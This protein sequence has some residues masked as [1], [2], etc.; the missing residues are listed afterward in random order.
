MGVM[1]LCGVREGIEGLH[2]GLN[3]DYIVS[4]ESPFGYLWCEEMRAEYLI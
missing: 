1:E 2:L 3:S 4:R